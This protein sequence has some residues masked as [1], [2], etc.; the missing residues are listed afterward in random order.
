MRAYTDETRALRALTPAEYYEL[1]AEAAS[2]VAHEEEARRLVWSSLLAAAVVGAI[3]L[4]TL[5]LWLL[6]CALILV[7]IA[8]AGILLSGEG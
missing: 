4:P 5:N 2:Q 3:G 1:L 7:A 6:S 8:V